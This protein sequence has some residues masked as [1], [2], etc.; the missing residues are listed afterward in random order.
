MLKM[1]IH[2]QVLGGLDAAGARRQQQIYNITQE[3]ETAK[4]RSIIS[5]ELP[6]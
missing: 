4:G 2:V 5:Q 6:D 1:F 3:E